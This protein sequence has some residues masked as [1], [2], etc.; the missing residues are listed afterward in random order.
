MTI[1]LKKFG[2]TLISRQ[3]GREAWLA[4]NYQLQNVKPDESIRVDFDGV[5]TFS[6]SWADEFLTPLFRFRSDGKRLKLKKSD[7]LSV[8][9]TVDTLE[10]VNK[11]KFKW[12]I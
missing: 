9:A 8:G 4:F 5:D 6:P 12:E 3:N 11:I 1:Q 2:N 7:N 10:E